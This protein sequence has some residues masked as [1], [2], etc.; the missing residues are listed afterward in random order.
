M[1]W[2]LHVAFAACAAMALVSCSS[3][4]TIGPTPPTDGII[5][6]LDADYV[7]TSLQLAI[8]VDDLG[9]VEG[10]CV[11]GDDDSAT[12]RWDDCVSS[13]RVMPGWRATLYRNPDFKGSSVTVT[14]DTSNLQR[15]PGPCSGSFNDC[16][17]SIRVS[18]Q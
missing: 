15:L 1:R 12:A 13:I 2:F 18:R 4:M 11:E 16:V 14:E 9:H 3:V 7:G 8:D 6:Y 10:P 17:S 5:I